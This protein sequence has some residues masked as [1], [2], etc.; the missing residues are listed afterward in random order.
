MSGKDF[1]NPAH[2]YELNQNAEFEVEDKKLR[3]LKMSNKLQL[4]KQ[5]VRFDFATSKNQFKV[6]GEYGYD[7]YKVA[8]NVD[9]KYNEKSAGDYDVTV[10]GS[11]NK[12]FF[13]FVSKRTMDAVKSKFQN[14][15]TAS[16]G[17]KIDLNG[18]ATNKFSEQDGELNLEGLFVA[19]E[20]AD[21][22]K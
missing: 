21:P 9:A 3:S 11:L 20:K 7:K 6:D 19:V 15:L 1:N 10:G 8:A 18:V 17:T 16:T 13:K 2:R 12:H 14:R 5:L 22:Y 4:P